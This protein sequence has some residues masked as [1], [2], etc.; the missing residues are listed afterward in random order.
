M[1]ISIISFGSTGDILPLLPLCRALKSH[2]HHP[3]IIAN[4]EIEAETIGFADIKFRS[5]GF[6]TENLLSDQKG[7]DLLNANSSTKSLKILTK[8]IKEQLTIFTPQI[9]DSACDADLILVNERYFLIGHMIVQHRKIPLIQLSFQPKGPTKEFPY[10]YYK[11]WFFNFFLNKLTHIF[12]DKMMLKQFLPII[13]KVRSENCHMEELSVEQAIKIKYNTPMLQG[14]SPKFFSEPK[15]WPKNYKAQGFWYPIP[16]EFKQ[17]IELE[18]FL[19]TE[20]LVIYVGFGSMISDSAKIYKALV[21]CAKLLDVK[22]IYVLNWSKKNIEN[23]EISDESIFVSDRI[24]HEFIFPLVDIVIH[25]GGS[26]TVGQALRFG[27]PQLIYCFMLD[28]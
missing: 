21:Q 17:S 4:S 7:T 3:T 11:P 2:G 15:D 18:S 26:G 10:L 22:F 23:T 14:F 28:Q 6:S 13:N 8:L 20:K 19:Q 24:P 9:L 12:V 27:K 16:Q 25:H 1:K 5:I